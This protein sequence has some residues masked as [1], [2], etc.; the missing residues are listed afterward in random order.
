MSAAALPAPL[1]LAGYSI[2]ELQAAL[3]RAEKPAVIRQI[4]AALAAERDRLDRE[5]AQLAIEHEDDWRQWLPHLFPQTFGSAFAPHHAE[6]WEWIWAIERDQPPSPMCFVG[7]WARGGAKSTSIEAGV[8]ALGARRRR[9]FVL[10]V[11]DKQAQADDHVGSIASKLESARVAIAYPELGS[12]LVGK[13]GD[14]KGWRRNRLRAANGFTVNALGLDVAARGIKIDDDR[15]DLIVFDDV[16]DE[17]DGPA[18]TE[19][20][21]TSI[22]QKLLPAGSKSLAVVGVQ[23]IPNAGGI[24]AQLGGLAAMEAEFLRDRIV[25]GPIPAIR[26]ATLEEQP[27]GGTKIIAGEPSWAGQSLEDANA[28]IQKMG[29]TAFLREMQHEPNAGAGGMFARVRFQHCTRAEIP[30]LLQKTLWCDPAVTETDHSDAHGIQLDGLAADGRIFRLRSWERRAS[31]TEALTLAICWAAIEGCPFI[32]IETDQ[33]GDTWGPVFREAHAK[34]EADLALQAAGEL[35]EGP[36]EYLEALAELGALEGREL[37]GY[38]A[39]AKASR[40]QLSKASRAQQMLAD[41]EIG[42][43]IIH[44][45]GYHLILERALQRFGR[46]KPFDLTDAAYW[47]WD[48]LRSGGPAELLIPAGQI[49][50]ASAGFRR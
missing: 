39:E 42:G 3:D 21:I 49:F 43:R 15:P 13:F 25:C 50:S 11:C 41:Y 6:F 4:S 18:I 14:S 26:D 36:D 34:V 37:P 30:D 5:Y 28:D 17:R 35:I 47:A 29:I 40:T 24:F 45:L 16:D 33:G 22:T 31:P 27:D 7:I 46:T 8:A 38:H 9:R 44:V 1:P 48:D 19:K 10:Y 20:K 23:N 32:G 2:D 12:R